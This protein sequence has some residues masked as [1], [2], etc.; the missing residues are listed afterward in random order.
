[1][2]QRVGGRGWP[3][4]LLAV[5][6]GGSDAGDGDGDAA[7]ATVAASDGVGDGVADDDDDDASA[8][9]SDDD[10]DDSAGTDTGSV[11]TGASDGPGNDES[12]GDE[13]PPVIVGCESIGTVPTD[14]VFSLVSY[15][16]RLLAGLFGYGQ[17]A[18]S[19][20]FAYPP[21]GRVEPGLLGISESVCAMQPF[22]GHLVANT[23]S[24]GDIVRSL[25][26]VSWQ[27]VWDGENGT[28]GCDLVEHAGMLY[29]VNYD[30]QSRE[31]G[32]I[33][34]SPD[35]VQWSQV[36][37]SGAGISRYLREVASFDGR[38]FA[39]S[40]DE[41]TQQGYVLRSQ[42]GV[43]WTEAPTPTRFFRSHVWE[44][45]LWLSSTSRGGNGEA[46]VWR[47]DG[48]TFELVHP[49]DKA[50]VTELVQWRG[51]LFAGTSDGWKD[52]VGT[53]SVLMS[54][55][56]EQWQTVCD[57]PELAVWAAAVHDDRLFV[58]TWEFEVGGGVYEV[59]AQ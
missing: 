6:C 21:W 51:A 7:T 58:G 45:A 26:G 42:D 56:G 3:V 27:V 31:N 17:E 9:A 5:A 12:G 39:F 20:L 25:D 53:S 28:I 13:A 33:L 23:E 10:D 1:M 57:L 32:R 35:G 40:V 54:P 55:D 30:N 52:D 8:D 50:Y 11:D 19:M 15:D 4:V 24:S 16:E 22:A 14:G 44:G 38:L 34:R 49:S 37:D 29:A 48:D 36:W 41:N 18:S 43:E 46:G 2:L 47:S 59:I